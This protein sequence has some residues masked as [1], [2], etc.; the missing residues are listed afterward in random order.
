MRRI[1]YFL[2]LFLVAAEASATYIVVLKNGTRYRAKDRWTMS[3]GKAIVQLENGTTIQ[4]D[5]NLIDVA[6]SEEATRSGYGDARVLATPGPTQQPA[7][8]QPELSLAERA[9]L[10]R[11]QQQQTLPPPDPGPTTPTR[12]TP[13]QPVTPT[14]QNRPGTLGSDVLSKF[15]AA[16]E[17]VGFYDAKVV[18]TVPYV[19]RVELNADNEDHVFKAISATAYVLTRVP[20]LTGARVDAVELYMAT[21][22][23][24]AAGRFQM[25]PEDAGA[26][27]SKKMSIENYFVR[28]VI[29]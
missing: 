25:T 21:L 1:S 15:T 2:V 27:D 9:R 29:F 28:K 3:G 7:N 4:L 22:N 17:N 18:S 5:P 14:T 26:L 16:Y 23:G 10:R 12:Q 6:R 8:Q 24:G 19:V 11:Q 20:A 13:A